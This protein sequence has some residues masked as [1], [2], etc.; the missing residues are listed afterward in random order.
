MIA[1]TRTAASPHPT[2]TQPSPYLLPFSPLPP[3][4]HLMLDRLDQIVL[5]RVAQPDRPQDGR[6]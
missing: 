1:A 4:S 3:H 2:P 5:L 6:D